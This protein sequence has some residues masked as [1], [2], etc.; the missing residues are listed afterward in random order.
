M[1][2]QRYL[3]CLEAD[4]ARL[5]EV[6]E[7]AMDERVPTCPDWSGADLVAHVAEV[8][9]H[10]TEIMRQGVWP[11]PWPPDLR[12]DPLGALDDGY[13]QL[14]GEFAT[15]SPSDAALT[16]YEPDQTVGFWLR[17]TAHETAIHRLDAELA[18]GVAQAAIPTDLAEDGIDE[19]LT[20][21]LAYAS[22]EDPGEFGE[23]L[24]ECDGRTVQVDTGGAGWQMQLGPTEITVERGQ[25]D[26]EAGV[27]GEPAAVL[28]WL[29]RRGGDDAVALD[30]N[31]WVLGKLQAML[32]VATQ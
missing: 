13:R 8:F 24:P 27:F 10:K 26:P 16:W 18:A 11:A 25:A 23:H 4:Y 9:L 6:A 1:D 14:V 20:V 7:S 22:V 21:F 12:A 29:W 2:E 17:R 31:R 28:R 15:R 32:E 5:R 30:G 19:L 3:E